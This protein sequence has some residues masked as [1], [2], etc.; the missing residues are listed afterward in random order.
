MNVTTPSADLQYAE[1][2]RSCLAGEKVRTR[3]SDCWRAEPGLRCVFDRTPLI[4]A[5]RTAWK[6]CL[7]EWGW[8]MSGSNRVSDLHPSVRPWWEPWQSEA[9]NVRYNYSR[10]FRAFWGREGASVD[11]IAT[12]I[13]GI[14][15]HPMSRRNVI[16][17]WNTADMVSPDCPITNCHGTVIQAT[18]HED[19]RL[20]L[21]TYQR[22]VDVICGLPHNWLQYWAF[23]L[24]LCARTE[25]TPGRLVWIGGDIHVYEAHLD[26]ARRIVALESLPEQPELVYT[27]VGMQFAA[28]EFRLDRDYRPAIEEKVVM[29]V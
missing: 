8:F 24:W 28:D 6:N 2:I 27:P 16:T 7:R 25:R 9:G 19:G 11:Q 26:L 15:L 20:T 14:R 5:R 17:T 12:L 29:V 10:Q 22:S 23:L 21:T 4:T 13:G 1:L 18:G 3:N